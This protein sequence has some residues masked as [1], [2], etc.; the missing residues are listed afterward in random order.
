MFTLNEYCDMYLVLGECGGNF[1]R[2]A[3]TYAVRYQERIHPDKNVFQRL[4]Q[5]MRE[6]GRVDIIMETVGRPRTART[7]QVE[8]AILQ[9]VEENPNIGIRGIGRNLNVNYSVVQRVLKSEAYHPFHYTK[10]Q[11]LS[12]NDFPL[13]VNFCRWM[14]DTIN[15]NPNFQNQILWTDESTFTRDGQLNMHNYHFYARE[16]PHAIRRRGFQQRFSV[17]VFA[18]IIGDRLIG[19][20]FLPHRLNGE[21]F[22]MFLR[23]DFQELLDN[24]PLAILQN[25]IW[26]QLDGAPAHFSRAVRDWLNLNYPGRWIGRGGHVAWPP[27]SCDLTPLDFFLWG[28]IKSIVYRTPPDNEQELRQRIIAACQTI[29]PEMIRNVQRSI[30]RRLE[31]CIDVNGQ[32]FEYLL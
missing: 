21:N 31:Q 14:L 12:E 24:V 26:L 3:A 22:L 17:N 11:A 5:R 30:T 20:Y 16:N 23:G 4:D 27:R 25:P 7:P 6:T 28:Y 19:P 29:T 9:A 8:E 15:L 2:A 13:R 1:R 18:G 32:N 10:V